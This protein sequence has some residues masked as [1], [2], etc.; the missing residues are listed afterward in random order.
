[1]KH[2]IINFLV[3]M[4]TFFGFSSLTS[5]D[6]EAQ[7]PE[8]QSETTASAS[9]QNTVVR[10]G[11]VV[12]RNQ[13]QS[14][15]SSVKVVTPRGHGSGS[16]IKIERN[17]YILTAGHVV[18]GNDIVGIQTSTDFV[19]GQVVFVSQT[20]DIG[21]VKIPRL[22]NSSEVR[23][24]TSSISDFNIG[25]EV[26]YSGY[27]GGFEIFT[28]GAEVAGYSE[29]KR[30]MVQGFAWPGSSGSGVIDSSGRVRG[31]V[32]AIGIGQGF[33]PQLLETMIFVELLS[34]DVWEQIEEALNIND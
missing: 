15:A 5:A 2:L 27:P 7:I 16:Y 24:R 30:I 23:H 4:L 10:T 1:M 3:V 22:A 29:N 17:Y 14:L 18:E 34:D 33:V 31:V 21:L 6:V 12:R 19:F 9:Y 25:E 32:I 28:S 20:H 8:I 26:V 11:S 13:A